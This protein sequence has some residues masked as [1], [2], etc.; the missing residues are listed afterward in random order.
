MCSFKSSAVALSPATT[1]SGKT[2]GNPEC[3]FRRAD[4]STY[5]GRPAAGGLCIIQ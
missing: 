2:R 3:I 1:S 4:C 5:I